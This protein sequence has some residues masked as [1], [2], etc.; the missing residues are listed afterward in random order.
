VFKAITSDNGAEFGELSQAIESKEYYPHPYTSCEQ[1]TNE[2]HNGLLRQLI[3]KASH[4][5]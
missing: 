4:G 3:P 1:G 5:G 2:R